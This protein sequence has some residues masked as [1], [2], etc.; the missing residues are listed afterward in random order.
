MSEGLTNAQGHGQDKNCSLK[1]PWYPPKIKSLHW[2]AT[3]LE[4]CQIV[5]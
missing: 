4:G 1:D 5:T 2:M 3:G